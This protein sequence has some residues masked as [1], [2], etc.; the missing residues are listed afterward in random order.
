MRQCNGFQLVLS[1]YMTHKPDLPTNS[2]FQET[3]GSN[4][5]QFSSLLLYSRFLTSFLCVSIPLRHQLPVWVQHSHH[6]LPNHVVFESFTPCCWFTSHSAFNNFMQKSVVSQNMANPSQCFLCQ[7]E[8][9]IYMPV[10]VYSPIRTSSLII[11]FSPADLFH[12]FPCPH[13]KG[14]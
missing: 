9:S 10:F 2:H 1:H 11:F 8:F 6:R 13:F 12:S 4:T 5:T 3:P 14:F 7:I